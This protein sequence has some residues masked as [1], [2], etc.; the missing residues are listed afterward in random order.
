MTGTSAYWQDLVRDLEDPEFL[1]EFVVESVRIATIDRVV[2]ALDDAR[3]AAGVSKADLARAIQVEPATIRRLFGSGRP[4]PTLGTLAEVAAALGVRVTIEPLTDD[5]QT[6]VT[7]PLLAGC[8]AD[9]VGLAHHLQALR[10]GS[11]S[12]V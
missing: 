6:H 1:R 11:A 9:T 4:N 8:T 2:N 12:P 10:T 7:E 5:E 3:E